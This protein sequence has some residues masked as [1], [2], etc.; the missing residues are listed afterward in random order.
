MT[1]TVRAAWTSNLAPDNYVRMATAAEPTKTDPLA[2]LIGE[3][4]DAAR[5]RAGIATRDELVKRSGPREEDRMRDADLRQAVA[6]GWILWAVEGLGT[7]DTDGRFCFG[8]AGEKIRR[9]VLDC[10]DNHVQNAPS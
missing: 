6:A 10:P 9:L 2:L 1:E 4:I 5:R 3:R 8:A 7:V